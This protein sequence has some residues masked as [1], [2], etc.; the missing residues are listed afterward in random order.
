MTFWD[1]QSSFSEQKYLIL[2]RNHQKSAC[3]AV[4][5]D[6]L[7][8]ADA[9]PKVKISILLPSPLDIS[10]VIA[11]WGPFTLRSMILSNFYGLY[12]L[13]A[14]LIPRVYDQDACVPREAWP[15][16]H[17]KQNSSVISEE[18]ITKLVMCQ[19]GGSGG[20]LPSALYGT[21]ATAME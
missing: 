13:T 21:A 5:G 12:E 16:R 20:V 7:E 11:Q 6:T 19:E 4:E 14:Q 8:F 15:N 9:N 17:L 18:H 1:Q 2:H 10:I 3:Y